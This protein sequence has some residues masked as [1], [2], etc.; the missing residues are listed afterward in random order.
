[1]N[2]DISKPIKITVCA[3]GFVSIFTKGLGKP[4]LGAAL[5][6]H[7][8]DTM[9]EA[10]FLI[11]TICELTICTRPDGNTIEPRAPVWVANQDIDQ[12]ES[13][14]LMFQ[15]TEKRIHKDDKP[16]KRK[17]NGLRKT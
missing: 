2:I 12:I 5:P 13:L 3:D 1:M 15:H 8:T 4:R 17:P 7:S 14:G 10:M 11:R 16:K 9:E 6:C